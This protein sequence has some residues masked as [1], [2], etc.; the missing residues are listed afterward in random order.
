MKSVA[1]RLLDIKPDAS[2][3]EVA[4]LIAEYMLEADRVPYRFAINHDVRPP[5]NLACPLAYDWT[6]RDV[7]GIDTSNK[8]LA[9]KWLT[10][11]V[12]RGYTVSQYVKFDPVG[13]SSSLQR[14]RGRAALHQMP[15]G[16]DAD[17]IP[18]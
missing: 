6:R 2:D 8:E 1:Q 13:R 15:K 14:A 3:R 16:D 4:M 7:V 9:R 12:L 10:N 18:F 5:K 11:A 17:D